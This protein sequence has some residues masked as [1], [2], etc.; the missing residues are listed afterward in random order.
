MADDAFARIASHDTDTPAA[1][2]RHALIGSTVALAGLSRVAPAAAAT[3]GDAG[4]ATT[5]YLES[6][7]RKL[8]YRS[9]GQG[10]PIVLAHRFR[11]VLDLWD[12]AFIDALAAQGFRVITFDHSG[13]GLS[14]GERSYNPSAMVKDA[15]D[16]IDGLRLQDVVIGGWS[17]G[18]IVAQIYVAMFGASVSHAVLIST[19][20]P[21]K[22]VKPGDQRFYDAAAQGP[23]TL[24]Q[25]TTLFFEPDD[26]ASRAASQRSFERIFAR[27]TGRSPDVPVE[28][29][30]SQVPHAPPN[31]MFPSEEVLQA[32]KHTDVPM[33]HL[34]GDHDL[35][36]PVENWYALNG[37]LPTMNLVTY[38]RAGHAPHHQHPEM[39]AAQIAAFIQNTR[40]A[41]A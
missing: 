16:L 27:K 20:P 22:L 40:K 32:L 15:K 4:S 35:S 7:G 33:L 9:V 39:A 3:R 8:A 23:A 29:A 31:P 36:V 24:D 14:T 12:P 13:I 19:T 30:L 25:Y 5:Q 37:Q 38:P 26:A 6:G 21:G 10:K 2:R 18:G 41:R 34:A 1:T 17:F 28:W 11:G